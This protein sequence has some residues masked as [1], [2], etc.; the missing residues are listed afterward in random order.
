MKGGD[1]YVVA[2]RAILDASLL[3]GLPVA[4]VH[5]TVESPTVPRHGHAWVEIEITPGAWFVQDRSNGHDWFGPRG[6]Y[7][8][9]GRVENVK[10]YEQQAAVEH[11]ARHQHFGPWE[12]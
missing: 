4:L 11:L 9:L 8:A 7:Y 12:D 6:A 5:G 2:G 3:G 10:R 1:C